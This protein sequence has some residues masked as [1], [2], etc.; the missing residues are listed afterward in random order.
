M[1]TGLIEEVGRV[2]SV[3]R[4]SGGGRLRIAA[5]KVLEDAQQGS[6]VSVNGVCLT[7]ARIDGDCF[8]ADLSPETLRVSNLGQLRPN[9]YV[10]LERAARLQDRLGGHLVQG[11]VDG[12]GRIVARRRDGECTVFR[13]SFPPDLARYLVQKG[14]VAVDGIS[15]TVSQL[16]DQSF[17]V[18]I[19]PFTLA[20]TNLKYRRVGD[21]VNLEC[22]LV[23]K[24]VERL[25]S[26]RTGG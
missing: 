16:L 25:L 21:A 1:F 11:H 2:L 7:M 26:F 10:N 4:G 5:S 23:G 9:A 17:E 8:A 12:S 19:I 18:S 20:A 14:S 22:D 3:E 15:L 6:S 24:Y 13:I